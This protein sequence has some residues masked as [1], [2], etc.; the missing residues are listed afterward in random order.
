M[1]SSRSTSARMDR[2]ADLTDIR[3]SLHLDLPVGYVTEVQERPKPWAAP[4]DRHCPPKRISS[5]TR[6]AS[7]GGTT[8]PVIRKA[9][10]RVAERFRRAAPLIDGI[11]GA[12]RG[13]RGIM[14]TMQRTTSAGTAPGRAC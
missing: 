3:A 4:P 1:D 5:Q 2:P 11:V 13:E 7:P 12:L 6:P 9:A 8:P 10:T 14:M